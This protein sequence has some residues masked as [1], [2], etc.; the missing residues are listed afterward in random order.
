MALHVALVETCKLRLKPPSRPW[1]GA[2]EGTPCAMS[3]GP[4]SGV[5]RTSTEYARSS[6]VENYSVQVR[7]KIGPSTIII[8]LRRSRHRPGLDIGFRKERV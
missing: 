4:V 6:G 2:L 8:S 7:S 1:M 5:L 3:T